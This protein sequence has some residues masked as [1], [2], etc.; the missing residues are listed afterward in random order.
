MKQGSDTNATQAILYQPKD[1]LQYKKFDIEEYNTKLKNKF[2]FISE[3][4]E[5]HCQSDDRFH[6]K[7]KMSFTCKKGRFCITK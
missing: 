3:S 7:S 4:E 6:L 2:N 1:K 5:S